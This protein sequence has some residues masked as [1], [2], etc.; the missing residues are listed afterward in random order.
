MIHQIGALSPL[1]IV[2]RVI[3]QKVVVTAV[4]I[5]YLYH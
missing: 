5:G 2:V 1:E 3:P 4:V